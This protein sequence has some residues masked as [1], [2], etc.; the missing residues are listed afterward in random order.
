MAFPFYSLERVITQIEAIYDDKFTSDLADEADGVAREEFVRCL[1]WLIV[2][3]DLDVHL[4][5]V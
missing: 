5:L 4:A 2:V 1:R 3:C